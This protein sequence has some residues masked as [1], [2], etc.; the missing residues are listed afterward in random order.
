[1]IFLNH[2]E[3]G[4]AEKR[5]VED[6]LK[7]NDISSN[8]EY[9]KKC[10]TWFLEHLGISQMLFTAS[11]SQALELASLLV[12]YDTGAEVIFSTYSFPSSINPFVVR[13]FVPVLAEIDDTGCMDIHWLKEAVGPKTR[14]VVIT[15][16]AGKNEHINEIVSYCHENEIMVIEDNAQG[17]LSYVDG[18]PLG[19]IGDIGILS[20]ESTKPVSCGEGGAIL[21][22]RQDLW[23]KTQVLGSNGTTRL[24]H[25]KNP[26]ISYTWEMPGLNCCMSNLNAAILY[27]QLQHAEQDCLKRLMLVKHYLS[28]FE[29]SDFFLPVIQTGWNASMFYM[30]AANEETSTF[31]KDYLLQQGIQALAHYGSLRECSMGKNMKYFGNGEA[32]LFDDRLIRLPL[33]ASLNMEVVD[34]ICD[35]IC[36]ITF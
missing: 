5:A 35:L 6:C 28:R 9:L 27:G 12:P 34:L 14:A 31:C 16:Y 15:N 33:Y 4:D 25:K 8:G 17:F 2:M 10:Y 29:K 18:V 32:K 19:C 30:I 22:N 3:I 20:F 11:G 24:L 13:G 1:M 21:I 26:E 36:D 7:N 23:K